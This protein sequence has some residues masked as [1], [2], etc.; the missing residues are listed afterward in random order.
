MTIT[1]TTTGSFF[2]ETQEDDT[3]ISGYR[4]QKQTFFI[5]F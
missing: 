4:I 2:S 5:T 3:K 1:I